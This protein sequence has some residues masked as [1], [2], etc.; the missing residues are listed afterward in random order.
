[1]IIMPRVLEPD[2]ILIL[3]PLNRGG[4]CGY[5]FNPIQACELSSP[6][7]FPLKIVFIMTIICVRISKVKRA[8]T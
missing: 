1:M 7:S 6:F 5:K 2:G 3:V 4:K 8:L